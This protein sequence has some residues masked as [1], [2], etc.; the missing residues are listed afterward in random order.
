MSSSGST[1]IG[2]ITPHVTPGPEVEFA[3][4]TG[5]RVT[6]RVARIEGAAGATKG[7]PPAL[8]ELMLPL[9]LD[10]AVDTL[11]AEPGDVIGYA[12]T[13]TAYVIGV[14]AETA[15]MSRISDRAGRPTVSTGAA[16][17]H[18]LSVLGVNRVALIGAPWFSAE[19]NERGADYFASQGFDVVSSTSA[20]LALDPRMIE[21][22]AV[23]DWAVGH[24]EDAADAVVFGG[25]GFRTAA[26]IEQLEAA[27]DRPV[28]TA[29][30][31]LLWQ[32]LSHTDSDVIV[33]GYGRLFADKATKDT[34]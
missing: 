17:L 27:I 2:V 1:S 7:E 19:L 32:L 24:V 13:T 10:R 4:M 8:R 18:A 6:T 3:L 33:G 34:A 26:A 21:P 15:A 14:A 9:H 22:A 5:G 31:V 20:Q 25:N 12:S 30:Q 29:N 16:T 11:L 23:V 28:L